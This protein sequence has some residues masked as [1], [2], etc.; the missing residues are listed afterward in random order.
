MEVRVFST[1]P[2]VQDFCG[3]AGGFGAVW[4][5]L[6]KSHKLLPSCPPA[7][8]NIG[9]APEFIEYEDMTDEQKRIVDAGNVD[10][11]DCLQVPPGPTREQLIAWMDKQFPLARAMEINVDTPDEAVDRWL[12]GPWH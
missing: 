1:A 4:C 11:L 12:F 5:K 3:F 8:I 7:S 9:M 6:P 10:L 2:I